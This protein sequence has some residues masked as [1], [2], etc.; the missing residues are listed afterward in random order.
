MLLIE[1][2]GGPTSVRHTQLKSLYESSAG[3]RKA[4]PQVKK[5]KRVMNFLHRSFPTKTPEL[6]KVN[7]LSLYTVASESLTKYAISNRAKEFGAWFVGFEERRRLDE[8]K[9]EDE[10]DEKM[11]SYQIAVLQQ[12]ANL[13]SQQERQRI[14]TE[15]MVATIPSLALLDDQR[16]F[17]YEQRAAIFRKAQGRCVNPDSQPDCEEE[18]RWD[19]FHAD[20]IV[21]HARGGKTTVEN[22]QLLCPKCNQ[23]KAATIK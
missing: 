1:L 10:R 2:R 19:S 8:G 6:S 11:V 14:L 16:H 21:P 13:A 9:S 20:H 23:K 17:T 12:T 3:F 22:G 18:C 7:L 5:V 4:S 15:D